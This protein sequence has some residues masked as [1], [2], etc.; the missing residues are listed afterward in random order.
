VLSDSR[1]RDNLET[2]S[3]H[4]DYPRPEAIMISDSANSS[5]VILAGRLT[6]KYVSAGRLKY[7]SEP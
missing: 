6:R 4:R 2:D 5:Q 1:H 7:V 3:L